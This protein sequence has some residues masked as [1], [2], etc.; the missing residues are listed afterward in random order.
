VSR[1]HAS[2]LVTTW[3]LLVAGAW[4][5]AGEPRQQPAEPVVVLLSWDG[6][7][8][9][10]PDRVDLPGLARM[11]Q[12][13]VR[14]GR[15]IPVYPSSTFP[16]HVSLATGTYPDRHGIIDNH[17]IDP[18]RG[19]FRYS[20]DADW[21]EA[22]PLWIAAERQ[23]VPVATYFWVG[24]ESDWRGRGTRY[25]VA[26]FDGARPE[27]AKVAQ[28]LE[29]LALPV[30]ERPRLIMSYWSGADSVGHRH[31]PDSRQVDQA[32]RDQDAQLQKLLA[33]VDALDAWAA[34]T[35][36][37][38]S[39]HGMAPV[40]TYIDLR[41]ILE[42]AGI[43]A[44]ITGSAVAQV[45]LEDPAQAA[46]ALAVVA[47]VEHVRAYR[48]D[49]IPAALRLRHP[50]RGGDLVVVTEP[51]Y[52]FARPAGAEGILMGALSRLGV[53]F[54]GHGYDPQQPDMGGIFFALGR[55]VPRGLVLPE[56]HQVD[57]AATVAR[58]LGIH[59]PGNSEGRA[60]P[61]IGEQALTHDRVQQQR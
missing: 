52:T 48:R 27:A 43:G 50:T 42:E 54:G 32:L 26:P 15:L 46:A 33:G 12:R 25:R 20:S 19:E 24:S 35:L 34:T 10:Y 22:E 39:D 30:A 8:H 59:P 1:L 57:V 51:P 3:L 56:V 11:A 17:F 61:G 29:W 5:V 37:I 36:I 53:T 47:G 7:R 38:V 18:S 14:A 31:G 6:I 58:L 16:T 4:A 9:D 49:E 40:G 23:G 44:R 28:I 55:G 41:G 45:H 2:A 21:L 13:G 60:V